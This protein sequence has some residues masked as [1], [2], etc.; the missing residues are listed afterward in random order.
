[1]DKQRWERIKELLDAAAQ[2]PTERRSSFLATSCA[3]DESLR[4]EV[5]NLLKHHEQPDN[6]LDG[7][8]A[9]D[10]GNWL[11]LEGYGR[12][13]SPGETVS[14]RF[15]IV[16]FIG[17][18]GMGEV[19][20]AEDSRLHRLVALKFLPDNV[21]QHADAL[22]RFQR[23]A[24]TASAM[25][26][27]NICTIYDISE[28]NGRAFIA[29]EL[30]EGHTLKHAITS[31]PMR[32]ERMLDISIAISDALDAAHTRGIIHRDI[33][34]EN[35]FI[36][37]RGD[38][39]ILDF[40]LAKLHR[41]DTAATSEVTISETWAFT[42]QGVTIGTVAYMSP[43][44]A[45]GEPLDARTDLFSFGLVMYEMATGRRAFS[46][47]TSAVIFA[48]LLK[49][50]PQPVSEINPAIPSEL[51]RIIEKALEKDRALRYQS[52]ADVRRDLD[53]FKQ[54]TNSK[55]LAIPRRTVTGQRLV[56]V[57][58]VRWRLAFFTLVLCVAIASGLYYRSHKSA[59]LTDKDTIVLA[60]FAN[61]TGDAVF[62]DTLKTALSVSLN[63][64]PFLNVLPDNKVAATLKLMTRP[65]DTK[66]TP[67]VARELCQR[68]GSKAYIAGS[69]A[70]LGRQCVVGLKAVNCQSG[71]PLAEEQVTAASK[72]KVL[73]A[74]GEAASKLR[75]EMGESLAT[76]QKFD[77]PLE[78]ATTSSLEALQ[79]YSIAKRIAR[80]RG[81]FPA[82]TSLFQRA[83]LLDSKFALA[84][85]ALGINYYNYG[86]G[87]LAQENAI[88]AYQLRERVSQRE[89]FFIEAI[90]YALIGDEEA[91]RQVDELW[92]QT[93]PRDALPRLHLGDHY[94]KV[95]QYEKAISETKE[96]L[97]LDPDAVLYGN[98]AFFYL[99]MNRFAE[100]KAAADEAQAKGFDSPYLHM[101]LYL[102]SFSQNDA[103]GM[104]QQVTW[105]AGRTEWG[106]TL[107]MQEA[108]TA[109][110]FGRMKRAREL[111]SRA[112]AMQREAGDR[113]AAA[114]SEAT[115]AL[116]EALFGNA[117]AVG[118][119][120]ASA[121]R[122]SPH[123]QYSG[124]LMALA[125]AFS[126]EKIQEAQALVDDL[127]R[128]YPKDPQLVPSARAQLALDRHDAAKAIEILD[129]T[130]PYELGTRGQWGVAVALYPSYL[131]GEAY[132]ATQQG[133]QAA[134]EFE[135]IIE[136][137][138]LVLNDPIG[139]LAHFQ[140]GRAYAM[141]G[142]TAKAKAAYHGFLTL[143]KDA[144][145]DIPILKQAK[146][147]YARLQ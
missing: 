55:R 59:Q 146:A 123:E 20:K 74:L 68:A 94:S 69:I 15:R 99:N 29:M 65:R 98:L 82:A 54:N 108:Q 45:H 19:Y 41:S 27:P 110:Y 40:G 6:F 137:R 97:Q 32:V 75:S 43:E 120:V 92:V 134:L 4:A 86:V 12:T 1:V 14:S 35:I 102:F 62:D 57:S 56:S 83:I 37:T 142:D 61:S 24:Q 127:S 63:Q 76:V 87:G 109:A 49:E 47:S 67:D 42:R 53:H 112:S 103:A 70:S 124:S 115:V 33:K 132:L 3:G 107:L 60:D 125:L 16:D 22:A 31:G 131:R 85:A 72:E 138:G 88:K 96:A 139:A 119:R 128:R 101:F 66:L 64:S 50:T 11:P 136:H 46:G 104:A 51:E 78:Q 13:F 39:K 130:T 89:R 21:A 71:D 34:P 133:D 140:S 23:E 121:L 48:A 143:W 141:S 117:S 26:H 8:V 135:K 84:Y 90:Y 81:D 38:P 93:Y 18:G 145:P 113:E 80:E 25:N 114:G 10:L 79:A 36:T 44:Q 100:A 2:L 106:G 147:E 77:V 105:S 30:L 7:N 28:H 118:P 52:A 5:E 58:R 9:V 122:S 73:D 91:S 17:R 116:C 126:H 129:F 144:D 95:G 111:Y